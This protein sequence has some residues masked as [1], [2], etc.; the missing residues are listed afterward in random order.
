[1]AFL[2]LWPTRGLVG[3]WLR[4]AG[5]LFRGWIAGTWARDEEEEEGRCRKMPGLLF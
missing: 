4:Q 5:T 3:S 2:F 1:M